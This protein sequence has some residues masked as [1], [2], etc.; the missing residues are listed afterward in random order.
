[1]NTIRSFFVPKIPSIPLTK[2][3]YTKNVLKEQFLLHKEYVLKRKQLKC[4]RLPG[5]PEDISE[6]IIK[7]ILHKVGITDST[8]NCKTGDLYSRTEGVQECKCFTSI[9]PMSFSPSSDWDCI[10]FLDAREWLH[11]TF[12]LYKC[13]HKKSS[14]EWKNLKVNKLQTFEDQC[15]QQR[16]PRMNWSLISSQI[17]CELIFEGLFNDIVN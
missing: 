15:K 10:Y 11:D 12:K 7:F 16:R 13:N 6:N 8:W 2:D 5:I 3:I 4:V 1:M 17:E 14:S 9:G